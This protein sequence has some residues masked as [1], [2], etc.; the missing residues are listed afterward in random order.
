[1]LSDFNCHTLDRNDI[2][3]FIED[4]AKTTLSGDDLKN[5]VVAK[6]IDVERW[7]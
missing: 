7:G 3:A 1:M 6:G 4:C 5:G 2:K